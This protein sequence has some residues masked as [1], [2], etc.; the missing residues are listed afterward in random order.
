MAST[1]ASTPARD[2]LEL[3]AARTSPLDLAPA[4]SVPPSPASTVTRS[5]DNTTATATALEDQSAQEKEKGGPPPP[6]ASAPADGVLEGDIEKVEP[7]PVADFP[8]GGWRAWLVVAGGFCCS[9]TVWGSSNS[10]G[11]WQSHYASYQLADRTPSDISWI[12]SFQLCMVMACAVL[13]GKLFDAGYIRYLLCGGT[14][15]YTAGL[16]GLAYTQNYAQIFLA[17]GLACGV[18]AGV[19][20]LGAVSSVSHWFRARRATALG[21]LA[22]GSSIG[23]VA[24]PLLINNLLPKIGF[25]H[26]VWAYGFLTLGFLLIACATVN[27]RLPPRKDGPILDFT[28]FKQ[29]EY[30]LFVAGDSLIMWGLYLPYFYTQSYARQHGVDSNIALYCLSILNAASLFG[31]IIPNY[32]ADTYGAF[33]ILIPNCI[34]SGVLVFAWIGLCKSTAGT[35]VFAILYGLTSGAYVSMMPVCVASITPPDQM[36][37]IGIRIAMAFLTISIFALTGTPLSGALITASNGSYVGAVVFSGVVVLL[38]SAFLV[39]AWW[40]TSRKKGTRWV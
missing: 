17:Q 8:D 6:F 1:T 28:V 21:I 34:A 38:G 12:G 7:A 13:S 20:F 37:R 14:L 9:F 36:N 24:Y 18:A 16:F 4:S 31:R 10:F 11:I 33:T 35:V 39:W 29:L 40:V 30:T 32:L 27:T 2:H 22:C 5:L 23:G 3:A 15:L 26:T 25:E 19:I